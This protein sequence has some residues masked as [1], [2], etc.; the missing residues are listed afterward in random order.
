MLSRLVTAFLPRSRQL[1]ISWFQSPSAVILEVKKLKSV[2]VSIVSPSICH[3]VIGPD[4]TTFVFWMLSFMPAFH[5]PLSLS[6]RA[7]SSSLSGIRVV[8]SVYIRLLVYLPVLFILAY[9]SSS[10]A[11]CMMY[12]AYKLNKQGDNIQPWCT[13]FHLAPVHCS[14][15]GSYC[16]FLTCMQISQEASKVI[17]YSHLFKN[18]PV[19]CDPH[20][21]R[22]W[23]SLGVSAN[24][25][26]SI[27]WFGMFIYCSMIHTI[28]LGN[29]STHL[30]L[31]IFHRE[32][33]NILSPRNCEIYNTVLLIVCTTLYLRYPELTHLLI[34]SFLFFFP[35]PSP[36]QPLVITILL[37]FH[38]LAF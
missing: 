17:W 21:Q 36:P 26:C 38:D 31:F 35:P 28:V 19:C 23:H 37:C 4:A 10:P 27:Y 5:S 9:A 13:P 18:F 34:A 12:S 20:S 2:S 32:I 30:I 15:S 8:S 11:F 6:S 33:I 29:P 24:L 22:L 16:C 1:L 25:R 14:M 7:S 3:E